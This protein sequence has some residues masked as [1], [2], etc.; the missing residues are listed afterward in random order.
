MGKFSELH[1]ELGE[2]RSRYVVLVPFVGKKFFRSHG[3]AVAYLNRER[4]VGRLAYL[5]G[6]V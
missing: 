6:G 3:R 4:A 2:R 5:F 1:I